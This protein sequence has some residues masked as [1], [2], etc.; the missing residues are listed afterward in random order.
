MPL[1]LL[2]AIPIAV[3]LALGA[4]AAITTTVVAKKGYDKVKETNKESQKDQEYEVHRKQS[5]AQD[6][7]RY[8]QKQNAASRLRENRNR[9]AQ[10]LVQRYGDTLHR[11]TAM[12]QVQPEPLIKVLKEWRQKQATALLEPVRLLDEEIGKIDDLLSAIEDLNQG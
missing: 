1:P 7:H 6:T 3:K 4:A 8:N 11:T 2:P 12:R 5:E 9:E 10:E